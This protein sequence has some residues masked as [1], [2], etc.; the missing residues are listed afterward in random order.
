MVSPTEIKQQ[1]AQREQQ[2]QQ[3][4][5][6]L[7]QT[8]ARIPVTQRQLLSQTLAGKTRLKAAE[9]ARKRQIATARKQLTQQEQLFKKQAAPIQKQIAGFEA[10]V[11]KQQTQIA[12]FETAKQLIRSGRAF[13]AQG[14]VKRIVDDLQAG[15][16]TTAEATI[17]RAQEFAALQQIQSQI[18]A[19]SQ[20]LDFQPFQTPGVSDFEKLFFGP[21]S[22][23]LAIGKRFVVEDG[24]FVGTIPLDSTKFQVPTFQEPTFQAPTIEFETKRFKD[25]GFSQ[26]QARRLAKESV[27]LGGVSFTAEAATEIIKPPIPIKDIIEKTKRVIQRGKEIR[28]PLVGKSILELTGKGVRTRTITL[29]S[30]ERA[31][32]PE[33]FE[34]EEEVP[35]LGPVPEGIGRFVETETGKEIFGE[36]FGEEVK[37]PPPLAIVPL[38]SKLQQL[39]DKISELKLRGRIL[40]GDIFIRDDDLDTLSKREIAAAISA[41]FLIRAPKIAGQLPVTVAE[42]L[43]FEGITTI[44]PEKEIPV[45]RTISEIP[46]VD[47]TGITIPGQAPVFGPQEQITISPKIPTPPEDITGLTI[48]EQEI[49]ATPEQLKAFGGFIGEAAAITIAPTAA[50]LFGGAAIATA[51]FDSDITPQE[52]AEGAFIFGTGAV[53]SASRLRSIRRINVA[54]KTGD[55]SKLKNSELEQLF[56]TNP[57]SKLADLK[58]KKVTEL[59]SSQQRKK[60][61][62]RADQFDDAATFEISTRPGGKVVKTKFEPTETLVG[63]VKETRKI[64]GVDKTFFGKGEITNT[65][66]YTE[67]LNLGK[68]MKKITIV[69]DTGEGI[70]RIIKDGEV[71]IEKPIKINFAND[72]ANVKPEIKIDKITI[73]QKST[74][75]KTILESKIKVNR[76]TVET[77]QVTDDAGNLIISDVKEDLTGSFVKGEFKRK[78]KIKKDPI[79]GIFGVDEELTAFL[80]IIETGPRKSLLELKKGGESILIK[81]R[82][83]QEIVFGADQPIDVIIRKSIKDKS[84]LK[85]A[86]SPTVRREIQEGAERR[87]VAGF[88]TP[89][90]E[91]ILK[92]KKA[93]EKLINLIK[94]D[95]KKELKLFDEALKN[96]KELIKKSL[97]V[98]K[99]VKEEVVERPLVSQFAGPSQTFADDVTTFITEQV[100][101]QVVVPP[102]QQFLT[103]TPLPTPIQIPLVPTVKLTPKSIPL[104]GLGPASLGILKTKQPELE[105]QEEIPLLQT[106]LQIEQREIQKTK[107]KLKQQLGLQQPLLQQP[108]ILQQQKVLQQQQLK[109]QQ[110]LRLQQVQVV[111]IAQKEKVIG[112]EPTPRPP[113]TPTKLRPK[114]IIWIPGISKSV[115]KRRRPIRKPRRKKEVF[116]AEVRRRGKWVSVGKFRKAKRAAAVGK[117]RALNTAAASVRV[118]KN[119]KIIELAP[120]KLFRESTKEPG[121]IIQKKLKRILTLGE[122]REISLI[123]ARAAKAKRIKKLKKKTKKGRKKK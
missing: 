121:I 65:G 118:R 89:D 50:L 73:D 55:F 6:Q 103:P 24:R 5:Q 10:A 31:I 28:I 70:V 104:G 46:A 43:G 38:P 30:G 29:P 7:A 48:P 68:N 78:A 58:S 53:I 40:F 13:E 84:L 94:Q 71:I 41:G 37:E 116:T 61:G 108:K 83:G 85:K 11:A 1:I 117:I 90:P 39:K 51:P 93:Q 77:F 56:L 110:K 122:K 59:L 99:E 66:E 27:K 75:S 111:K 2:F 123:G 120:S 107:I 91:D 86:I 109:L 87:V 47:I 101:T 105:L 16:F 52:R 25:A 23:E 17:A 80:D 69:D 34:V 12:N 115:L 100:P 88:V 14:A 114:P 79:T 81:K 112:R 19:Q 96:K 64:N 62:L 3:A 82:V 9:V 54:R 8:T 35:V 97:K 26:I 18:E 21:S 57:E 95:Q 106:D 45:T 63:N 98:T 102:T 92:T 74:P 4:R 33:D 32:V 44:V 42:Q 20:S 36:D 76:G 60:I 113:I 49:V 67:V 72:L 119:G 15:G 22:L